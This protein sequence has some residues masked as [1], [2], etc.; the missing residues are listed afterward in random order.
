[1]TVT[2]IRGVRHSVDVVA[3]SMFEAAVLGLA[4][5]RRDAWVDRPGP[6][7]TLEIAVQEVV[8]HTVNVRQV[9]R[10]LNG[11]TSSPNEKVKRERLKA[12]LVG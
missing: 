8:T 12:L 10:W 7:T 6:G 2:D 11:A 3:E 1:M 9:E 4:T 5:F